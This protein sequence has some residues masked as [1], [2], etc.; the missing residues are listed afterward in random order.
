MGSNDLIFWYTG[1]LAWA[2]IGLVLAIATLIGAIV[3]VVQA[4]RAIKYWN[5]LWRMCWMS[6]ADMMSFRESVISANLTDEEIRKFERIALQF[7]RKLRSTPGPGGAPLG[8]DGEYELSNGDQ[9]R[10]IS[11]NNR[12][13]GHWGCTYVPSRDWQDEKGHWHLVE[14]YLK[15]DGVVEGHPAI[16]IRR[17]IKAP[18]VES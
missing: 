16:S 14:C 12:K 17:V 13:D 4:Y 3:C 7:R 6:E 9:V 8:W 11:H 18:R 15:T 1:W 5:A 10:V 2:G